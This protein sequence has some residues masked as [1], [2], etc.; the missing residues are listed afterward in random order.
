MK[1]DNVP[2]D[3]KGIFRQKRVSHSMYDIARMR[4]LCKT[5]VEYVLECQKSEPIKKLQEGQ[6]NLHSYF[7]V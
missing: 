4:Y 1:T 2:L 5:F 3:I 6:K 7:F